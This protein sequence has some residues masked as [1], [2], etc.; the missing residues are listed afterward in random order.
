MPTFLW[1]FA[2]VDG[3][4]GEELYSHQPLSATRAL[5]GRLREEQAREELSSSRIAQDPLSSSR[6]YGHNGQFLLADHASIPHV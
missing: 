6:A 4:A 5:R 3:D 2:R 1:Q